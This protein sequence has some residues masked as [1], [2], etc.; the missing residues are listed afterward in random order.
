MNSFSHN[1]T[2]QPDTPQKSCSIVQDFQRVSVHPGKLYDIEFRDVTVRYQ[3]KFLKIVT[4]FILIRWFLSLLLKKGVEVIVF[5]S[6][7]VRL[8]QTRGPREDIADLVA[9]RYIFG[10]MKLFSLC[11]IG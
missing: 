7:S 1:A 6:L 10:S 11:L 2:K 3:I 4:F 8:F 9:L 5:V